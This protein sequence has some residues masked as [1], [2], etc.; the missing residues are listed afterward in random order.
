MDAQDAPGAVVGVRA[1]HPD[2]AVPGLNTA[3]GPAASQDH[4]WCRPVPGPSTHVQPAL[5]AWRASWMHAAQLRCER[6]PADKQAA[7]GTVCCALK[8][9]T[10][11]RCSCRTKFRLQQVSG[12]FLARLDSQR[13]SRTGLASTPGWQR[14]LPYSTVISSSLSHPVLACARSGVAEKRIARSSATPVLA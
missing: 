12:G 7:L 6:L 8:Q 2:T 3:P 9:A 11:D 14:R 13:S 10:G 1:A 5:R 4:R